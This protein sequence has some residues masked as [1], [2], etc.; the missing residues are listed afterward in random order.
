MIGAANFALGVTLAGY[1]FYKTLL[2]PREVRPYIVEMDLNNDGIKDFFVEE[3]YFFGP[4]YLKRAYIDW[5]VRREG[6][7]LVLLTREI[8]NVNSDKYRRILNQIQANQ[9]EIRKRE[10]LVP[11]NFRQ[12]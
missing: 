9:A 1:T 4:L 8:L 2:N 7:H 3:H 11:K 6:D 5:S 12:F 10:N